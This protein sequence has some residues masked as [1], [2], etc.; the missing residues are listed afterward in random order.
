M[1]SARSML[2]VSSCSVELVSTHDVMRSLC[3][4][5]MVTMFLFGDSHQ[6]HFRE[7]E[8][9]LVAIMNAVA[10]NDGKGLTLKVN[11]ASSILKLATSADFAFCGSR[12]K[13]SRHVHVLEAGLFCHARC[14][15]EC[16]A[17]HGV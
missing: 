5:T 15:V 14:P 4:G 1:T 9:S 12:K 2:Y 3:A 7:S 6:E 8:G 10:E 13:V 11:E 17:Q 16:L